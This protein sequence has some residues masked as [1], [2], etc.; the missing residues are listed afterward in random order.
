[1]T[2]TQEQTCNCQNCGAKKE[3]EEQTSTI[4]ITIVGNA[5]EANIEGNALQLFMGAASLIKSLSELT[6]IP[7]NEVLCRIGKLIKTNQ[8]AH[9]LEDL[10]I[11]IENPEIEKAL[12]EFLGV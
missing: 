12:R 3:A 1:M 8:T 5:A 6:N 9:E 4:H 2:N 11:G 10:L 7:V